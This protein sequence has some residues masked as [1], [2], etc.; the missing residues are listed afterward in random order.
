MLCQAGVHSTSMQKEAEHFRWR[1]GRGSSVSSI[2]QEKESPLSNTKKKVQKIKKKRNAQVFIWNPHLCFW[3][4]TS[5]KWGCMQV[6][7]W[8][9]WLLA[10]VTISQ[11][12]LTLWQTSNLGTLPRS[13]DLSKQLLVLVTK[14]VCVHG[15]FT[16]TNWSFLN[17]RIFFNCLWHF[18][19]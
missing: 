4:C 2:V 10:L 6:T 7:I 16:H 14:S 1:S 15:W 17:L 11:M 19:F 13:W 8:Q 12:Q 3:H 5:S 18:C 9:K